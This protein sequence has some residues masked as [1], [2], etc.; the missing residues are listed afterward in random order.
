ME[1]EEIW[2]R[3]Q[4]ELKRFLLSKLSNQADAE[5]ILQDVLLKTHANLSTIKNAN[6]IK[7]WLFQ[8]TNNAI[9]DYYRQNAK[10]KQ[11]EHESLWFDAQ[12][13][14]LQEEFA[15]CIIP[16]ISALPEEH[17]AILLAVDING[18]AQKAYAQKNGIAYSTFKSQVQ[19]S[20]KMLKQLFDNCCSFSL[21]SKGNVIDYSRKHP[22][23]DKC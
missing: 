15:A 14:T 4:L 6:S 17:A 12:E 16:F 5:D 21:D 3:Y 13:T 19:K 8:V 18:E 7:P 10:A 22:H 11:I 2:K 1:L 23:C 9:I 20:R